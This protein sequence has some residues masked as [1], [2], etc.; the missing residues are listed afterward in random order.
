MRI[1]S[2]GLNFIVSCWLD[3]HRSPHP[4]RKRQVFGFRPRE[5]NYKYQYDSSGKCFCPYL[6]YLHKLSRKGI[7]AFD[8]WL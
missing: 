6:F 5:F 1:A 3:K 2:I 8:V 4:A 7:M